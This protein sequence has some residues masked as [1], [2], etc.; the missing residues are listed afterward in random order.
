MATLGPGQPSRPDSHH[1]YGTL[2][3]FGL[4]GSLD[5][6]TVLIDYMIHPAIPRD[7]FSTLKCTIR[8]VL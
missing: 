6:E 7:P 5:G 2:R 4:V 8:L 1:T 3:E